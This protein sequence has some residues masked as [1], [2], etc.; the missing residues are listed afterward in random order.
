MEN[1]F[2]S[3]DCNVAVEFLAWIA[4]ER[5][6][7]IPAYIESFGF[8]LGRQAFA[9]TTQEIAKKEGEKAVAKFCSKLQHTEYSVNVF[10]SPSISKESLFV[11][12]CSEKEQRILIAAGFNPCALDV[13]NEEIVTALGKGFEAGGVA[14]KGADERTDGEQLDALIDSTSKEMFG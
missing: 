2:F 13:E 12:L 4:Y 6:T 5:K 1:V 3:D 14:K 8:L 9:K 7:A 11:G 10:N